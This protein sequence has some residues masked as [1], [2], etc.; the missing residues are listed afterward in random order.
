LPLQLLGL[1]LLLLLAQLAGSG[2]SEAFNRQPRT[3]LQ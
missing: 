1:L 2:G 3:L